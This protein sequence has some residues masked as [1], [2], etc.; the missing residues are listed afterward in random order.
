MSSDVE[1]GVPVE[2]EDVDTRPV[3]IAS[4]ILIVDDTPANLVAAEAALAPL[5]RKIVTA[6]SGQ[7]ALAHLLEQEFALVLLDV[8]MP[9]MDG[10]E[11]ARFIRSYE[12]THH[13][14][15]I[16]MTA[17]D[18]DQS[19]VLRAYELG[20]V[21]FLFTPVIPEVL[22]AK[23]SVFVALHERTEQLANER[24]ERDFENRR[25]DFE[26]TALRRQ[27][28]RE[29]AANKELARLNAALA[30]HD[31]RK[32]SFIAILAH[33]LRNPLAPLRTCIELI[34][35]SRARELTP[36]MVDILERQTNVLVRLIDDLLD[37]SRIKADKIELRPEQVDLRD[38]VEAAVMTSRP[39]LDDRR[40]TLA[41][42][43]PQTRVMV[44]A[45]TVRLVQVICN[46]I[47]NAARYTNRGGR[48]EITLGL[49]EG[50]AFVRVRDNGIGIPAELQHTIFN[51]FVQERARSDGS[52]GLGLG[53]ALARRLIELHHGSIL[54]HSDGV[55]RGSTF[56]VRIPCLGSTL[57]L[58][59]RR[60][61]SDMEPL[62]SVERE[63]K[64]VRTVVIDDND[65]A[66]E[67]LSELLRSN[68]YEVLTAGDGASGLGLI[69]EHR[70]EVAFV[71]LGLPML[72]GCGVAE[73]LH[74]ECPDLKTRLIALTG[75]GNESD[76]ERTTRA[77]FHA[78][79]VKP[80]TAAAI[81]AC[82]SKQ[83]AE[84]DVSR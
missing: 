5:D 70:P 67:L 49:D 75:Y 58:A 14:P 2:I 84:F 1:A 34:R 51:M 37:L 41:V 59:P 82:V 12:R 81:I 77:G 66:R 10:Y 28:D 22:R 48:I 62:R 19:A 27:R 8:N 11:T 46:L 39:L 61:T 79:L 74:K 13:V 4:K 73:A 80:A 35:R 7:E 23:A 78:H 45:D 18:Y 43:A 40:H 68:G 60:R 42:D 16:F 71:D 25:R 72:D 44:V 57:A 6:G 83:L 3:I 50:F 32:D 30:E 52:G 36:K 33:E 9:G 55:N 29:L 56:E 24:L 38:V 21:D 63:A 20:A 76:H 64:S 31:R 54:C 17:Q 15:I 26:A 47:N 65:D 69:R 53:L